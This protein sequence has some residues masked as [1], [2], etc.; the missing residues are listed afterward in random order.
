MDIIS[1]LLQLLIALIIG[2]VASIVTPYEMP[3]SW[4]GAIIAGF[5]GNWLGTYLFGT[6]G[7][8]LEGFSLVPALFGA[9]IVSIIV[10]GV[11]KVVK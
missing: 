1:L 11:K 2:S 9:M 3:G 5:A 7:P 4:A 6:W 10:G 8:M